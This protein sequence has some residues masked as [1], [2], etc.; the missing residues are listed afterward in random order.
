MLSEMIR[1]RCRDW[2]DSL[3]CCCQ[4]SQLNDQHSFILRDPEFRSQPYAFHHSLQAN[5]SITLDIIQCN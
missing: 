4:M 1:I 3:D 5:A 2:K